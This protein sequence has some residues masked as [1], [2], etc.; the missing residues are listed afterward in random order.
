[1]LLSS[2]YLRPDW[3]INLYLLTNQIFVF[4][5]FAV[6]KVNV[7]N[8]E[9]LFLFCSHIKCSLSRLEFTKCLSEKQTGKTLIRY[10]FFRSGLI[11][12]Y[13]V[14]QGLWQATSV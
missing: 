11:R 13:P 14:C 12:V 2:I 1:M 10:G 4:C 8:F 3:F 6:I 9:K 7:L 5:M